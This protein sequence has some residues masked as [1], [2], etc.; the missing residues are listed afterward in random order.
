MIFMP[1][2]WA[3]LR[4]EYKRSLVDLNIDLYWTLTHRVKM[5]IRRWLICKT[6][7]LGRK[8]KVLTIRGITA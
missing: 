2:Y 6:C 8:K 1:L 7:M 3:A 5:R 4:P